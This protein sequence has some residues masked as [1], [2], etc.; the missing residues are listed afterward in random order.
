MTES[1]YCAWC[2]EAGSEPLEQV[3]CADEI[4]FAHGS[5]RDALVE[6]CRAT[7]AAQWRFLG[8]ILSCVMVAVVGALVAV[9][10][11]KAAGAAVA[12][13][14]IALCG[15]ILLK[16]PFTTPETVAMIGVRRS[17][18]LARVSAVVLLLVAVAVVARGVTN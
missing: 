2:R 18:R 6:Y 14:A 4:V 3:T 16:Y 17:I 9:S 8:G 5:H 12:G 15:A 13:C 11:S 10:G 1:P 7:A